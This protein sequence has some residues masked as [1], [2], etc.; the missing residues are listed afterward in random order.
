MCTDKNETRF[1]P[2]FFLSLFLFLFSE[3]GLGYRVGETIRKQQVQQHPFSRSWGIR[4]ILTCS[5][6]LKYQLRIV[7]NEMIFRLSGCLSLPSPVG[8]S[9]A[10]QSGF[11]VSPFFSRSWYFILL[12]GLSFIYYEALQDY[13]SL[14][15]DKRALA[16]FLVSL[17]LINLTP[18]GIVFNHIKSLPASLV[19]PSNHFASQEGGTVPRSP[20]EVEDWRPYCCG[21]C[22]LIYIFTSIYNNNNILT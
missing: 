10:L 4:P 1:L 19:F 7:L 12:P 13:E 5:F 8:Q 18:L 14:V 17:R 6:H 20:W 11:P 16:I 21:V 15:Y 2:L 3:M 22:L 9:T